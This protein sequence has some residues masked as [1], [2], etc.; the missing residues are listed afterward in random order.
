ML[1]NSMLGN[2]MDEK[3]IGQLFGSDSGMARNEDCLFG[4]STNYNHYS[5]LTIGQ[6]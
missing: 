5:I 4:E 3:E 2:D 1:R 6:W